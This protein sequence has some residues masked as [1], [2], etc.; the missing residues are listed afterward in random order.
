[1]VMMK[2]T[3]L[4]ACIS[5]LVSSVAEAQRSSNVELPSMHFISKHNNN[6]QCSPQQVKGKLYN[7]SKP[8]NTLVVISHGSQGVDARHKS[9][10]EALGSMGV[11]A[12]VI[13]HWG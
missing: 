12:L 10:A 13:D 7:P 6:D 4:L 3:C 9:Y 8:T 11:A 1:P 2:T 5:L